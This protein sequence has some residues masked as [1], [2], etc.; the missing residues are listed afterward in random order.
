MTRNMR[1]GTRIALAAAAL[2]AL[3]APLAAL[4]LARG[5]AAGAS[6][7][8]APSFAK[9]VAPVVAEKCAGCHRP[10][11][12]APFSLVTARQISSSSAAIAAAVQANIMP[13]WPPGKRS[14]EYVGQSRG[15]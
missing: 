9:D 12:I 5:D 3:A 6:T 1:N 13:P 10:G 14:P 11:G 8:A 4:A 7:A 15:S 2:V